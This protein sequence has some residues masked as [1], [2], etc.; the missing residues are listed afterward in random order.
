MHLLFCFE[1]LV[2][3]GRFLVLSV[4]LGRQTETTAPFF[5]FFLNEGS[6]CVSSLRGPAA[7][8]EE[9]FQIPFEFPGLKHTLRAVGMSGKS[10]DV[11][12]KKN[13][14]RGLQRRCRF[15]QSVISVVTSSYEKRTGQQQTSYWTLI[16][17]LLTTGTKTCLDGI[18]TVQQVPGWLEIFI[19]H[20]Y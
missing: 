10:S 5:F 1:S 12:K 8:L 14:F 7:G 20:L 15:I 6:N 9:Y 13:C 18:L 4:Y 16:Q 3:T 19:V 17:D 11:K 2:Q